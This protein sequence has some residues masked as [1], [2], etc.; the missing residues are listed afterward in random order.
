[1]KIKKVIEKWNKFIASAELLIPNCFGG[2]WT[3]ETY[4]A[5][6][7]HQKHNGQNTAITKSSTIFAFIGFD[8]WFLYDKVGMGGRS[9]K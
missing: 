5:G 7:M 9:Q 6:L 3:Y 1:M 8:Y 4:W 2:Y